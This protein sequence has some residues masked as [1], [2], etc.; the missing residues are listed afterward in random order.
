M[1]HMMSL[2]RGLLRKSCRKMQCLPIFT[3]AK[4][5]RMIVSGSTIVLVP[6]DTARSHTITHPGM[7]TKQAAYPTYVHIQHVI[8]RGPK[9]G[10]CKRAARQRPQP[11]QGDVTGAKQ[12][13][14]VSE[15]GTLRR[16]HVLLV[17]VTRGPTQSGERGRGE[18][19]ARESPHKYSRARTHNTH[20]THTHKGSVANC[21]GPHDQST[22]QQHRARMGARSIPHKDAI[23]L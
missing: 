2:H 23:H 4:S 19:P 22:L 21:N 13:R 8:V 1:H 7:H 17:P 20:T 9:R 18:A 14:S 11:N 3:F 16:F 15:H 12:P 5:P 10:A 6:C